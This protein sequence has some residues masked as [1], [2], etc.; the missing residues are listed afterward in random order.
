[1]E[2][3]VLRMFQTSQQEQYDC[4]LRLINTNTKESYDILAYIILSTPYLSRLDKDR[5]NS[6][7]DELKCKPVPEHT[8][9]Y[10]MLVDNICYY[11]TSI[12]DMHISIFRRYAEICGWYALMRM[13]KELNDNNDIDK[14]II[15]I[16]Y[17]SPRQTL[18]SISMD[19]I[20]KIYGS[21]T[22]IIE[23]HYHMLIVIS[24][25]Y[26]EIEKN[27]IEFINWQLRDGSGNT[28]LHRVASTHSA[29]KKSVIKTLLSKLIIKK[30]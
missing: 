23:F 19:N 18:S 24:Q 9:Q 2:S 4:C 16:K 11:A 14:L 6:L 13:L 3:L 28:L 30:T 26:P 20:L 15:V 29:F 1:M 10:M 12:K 25:N 21:E 27:K 8:D 17:L 22:C 7:F 5:C